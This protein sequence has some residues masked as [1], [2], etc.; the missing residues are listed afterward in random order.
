MFDF[1]KFI[2]H[3]LEWF[4]VH[5]KIEQTVQST[6]SSHMPLPPHTHATV[7]AVDIP[8]QSGPLVAINEPTLTLIIT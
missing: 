2:I 1:L 6:K 5:S 3:F 7:P 8:H 4:C